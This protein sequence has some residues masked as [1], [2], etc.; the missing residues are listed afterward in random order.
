[1]RH[2]FLA[3][4]LLMG[5]TFR[6][7]SAVP[8]DLSSAS[9]AM[10]TLSPALATENV[11]LVQTRSEMDFNQTQHIRFQQEYAGYLVWGT[12]SVVH[13]AQGG[14]Y[15]VHDLA[16]LHRDH[17]LGNGKI[18]LNIAADLQA[19][20]AL[21][22]NSVQVKTAEQ[23]ALELTRKKIGDFQITTPP[24]MQ[25]IVYVDEQNKAHW[26]YHIHFSAHK[27][28]GE[29]IQPNT[30][31]DATNFTEYQ[32]W[33]NVQTV[34]GGGFG[35]N[36]R[37]GKQFYDG[38]NKENHLPVL[39]MTRNDSV[40]YLKNNDV[41]VTS[42]IKNEEVVSFL[43]AEPD[44]LHQNLF[45]NVG[46]D[47]VNGAF[48]PANDALFVGG[49][50]KQ[51]YQ[52]WYNI[53]VLVHNNKPMMLIM[54]VHEK[55]ENAYWDGEQMTFGDG[56]RDF[57]PL[58]SV[59]I[60]AHEISHGFTEQHAGLL[61]Y[62]E[63][64]ALD[65]SFSDM[66]AQAAEFYVFK[67][68]SWQIGAEVMKEDNQPLRYMDEPTKDC[69]VGQKPGRQCSISHVKDYYSKL[70][71]HFSSGIF[72]KLFY[73]MSTQEGWDTRKA[74]NVMVQANRYYWTPSSTFSDAG[75]GVLRATEDFKYDPA[76]V[77]QA[78]G[79]VGINISRC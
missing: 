44:K 57:Y 79:V 18:Y 47:Y 70:D 32:Y 5:T 73:L 17:I 55:M 74:F 67:K 78:L 77:K 59:G 75:C 48:S 21:V 8:V 35:G 28:N 12:Q 64:G 37:I 56:G 51:M 23:H 65:E 38:I 63:S 3:V 42:M 45:W 4:F 27:I 9:F 15:K 68:S 49:V 22:F 72:N 1:M 7:F 58:V 29:P 60:A 40:C 20:P 36:K 71:V 26:A 61:Y 54:R 19:T 50:V 43:C 66:A 6:A 16:Q 76:L 62:G 31:L 39:S 14:R 10:L 2:Y 41:M 46:A 34:D 33:N 13:V 30:I 53:P 25:R 69:A 11:E 24:V 52:Q